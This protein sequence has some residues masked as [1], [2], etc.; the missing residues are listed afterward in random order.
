MAARGAITTESTLRVVQGD[1]C[2]RA[3]RLNMFKFMRAFTRNSPEANRVF[4]RQSSLLIHGRA[5]E[6]DLATIRLVVSAGT[7]KVSRCVHLGVGGTL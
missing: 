7:L 2:F 5:C 3:V 4:G 6:T 1:R